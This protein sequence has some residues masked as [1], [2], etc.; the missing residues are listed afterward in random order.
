MPSS[1]K[2][3]KIYKPLLTRGIGGGWRVAVAGRSESRRERV[4]V[5]AGD[6]RGGDLNAAGC[7]CA[8]AEQNRAAGEWRGGEL[9][10]A[11]CWCAGAEQNRAAGDWRGGDLDGSRLLVRRARTESRCGRVTG[12]RIERSR[13]LMRR[14]GAASC[15]GR[16]AWRRTGPRRMLVR[17][18]GARFLPGELHLMVRSRPVNGCFRLCQWKRKENASEN[19]RAVSKEQQKKKR[20]RT[21]Q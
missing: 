19:K 17:R 3:S 10:A 11:G 20:N 5:A 6:W 13:L 9:N 21:K 1:V 7:W 8:G 4:A 14:G 12:R 18:A 15:C 16:V 2:L